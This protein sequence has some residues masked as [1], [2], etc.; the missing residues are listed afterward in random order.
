[1]RLKYFGLATALKARKETWK[2]L[3]DP[4]HEQVPSF[5][6]RKLKTVTDEVWKLSIPVSLDSGLHL[7]LDPSTIM[8][9]IIQKV[10][11]ALNSSA[12]VTVFKNILIKCHMNN[13]HIGCQTAQL[14][15]MLLRAVINSYKPYIDLFFWHET[16]VKC[17]S[18]S[19]LRI[20]RSRM[21]SKANISEA[22]AWGFTLAPGEK[23]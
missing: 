20:R 1:M 22:K 5:V 4:L 9:W 23:N 2:M 8:N 10:A 13:T 15:T 18:D 11:G 12:L 6:E 17:Y 7:A 21:D 14:K 16:T 19:K 3:K